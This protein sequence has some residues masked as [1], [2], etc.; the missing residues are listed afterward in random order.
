MDPA[1][2]GRQTLDGKDRAAEPASTSGVPTM[3][4]S[5][6][7]GLKWVKPSDLVLGICCF[8]AALALLAELPA[9]ARAQGKPE[10]VGQWGK[11]FDLQNVAIHTHVLPDGRVLYWSRREQ[12]EDL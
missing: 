7:A 11:P 8:T 6:F 2:I 3:K 5:E 1:Q 4:R 9:P 10:E 12:G